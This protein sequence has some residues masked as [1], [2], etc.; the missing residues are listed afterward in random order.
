MTITLNNIDNVFKSNKT[1]VDTMS[2]KGYKLV[3]EFFIDN[4]GWG[5]DTELA[6]TK[7]QFIS[8]LKKLLK[9][10]PKVT[11]KIT[12]V[13]QFQVYL[14]VFI[15]E[16]KSKITKID[17]N[18]Y[19]YDIDNGYKIRLHDTDI[20]TYQN[21]YYTLNSGGWYSRTTKE[22]LNKYTPF[23]IYQKNYEW[24]IDYD[25]KTLTF[26]DNIKIKAIKES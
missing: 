1:S 18:T 23:W 14:G 16:G 21:G 11:T 17:N 19:K 25:N 7:S 15:K 3:K 9:K 4:S 5:L 6:L 12:D 26:N 8:E 2:L 24:Y 22:R 13:G 10:Y 20:I